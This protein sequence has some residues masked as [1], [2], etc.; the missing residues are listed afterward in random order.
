MYHELLSHITFMWNC[1]VCGK[2]S[3]IILTSCIIFVFR[4]ILVH[5][6]YLHLVCTVPSLILNFF[7]KLHLQYS[8]FSL[9]L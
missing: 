2:F 9:S 4:M 1:F 7:F 5:P 3:S 8:Y 6:S